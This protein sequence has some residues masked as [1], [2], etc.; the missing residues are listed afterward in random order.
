MCARCREVLKY[1]LVQLVLEMDPVYLS[2]SNRNKNGRPKKIKSCDKRYEVYEE[3]L[4]VHSYR[5]VAQT[6]NIS[7]STAERI[8]KEHKKKG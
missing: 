1:E 3:Y 7:K 8:V 5:K 2:E 6:Y 4:K